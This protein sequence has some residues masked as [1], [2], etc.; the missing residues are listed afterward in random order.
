MPRG[1]AQ[2]KLGVLDPSISEKFS[3]IAPEDEPRSTLNDILSQ[4]AARGGV[5]FH[6]V[7]RVL[8]ALKFRDRLHR[9]FSTHQTNRKAWFTE[10]SR[11][12]RDIAG[13]EKSLRQLYDASDTRLEIILR[14]TRG[15]RPG[16]FLA[17]DQAR[18]L[19]KLDAFL[20]AVKHDRILQTDP[21]RHKGHQPQPWLK[22]ADDYLKKAGVRPA[23]LREALLR[24]TGV[25]GLPDS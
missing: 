16:D 7:H 1:R 13:V 25:K 4:L 3:W 9:R 20:D 6:Q 19:I 12:L 22:E 17:Q 10:R 5:D 11:I 14:K 24:V 2:K 21:K 23:R 8:G 15:L 18:T